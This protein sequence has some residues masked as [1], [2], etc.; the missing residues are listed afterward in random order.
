MR[1]CLASTKQGIIMQEEV[2]NTIEP[3]QEL[4]PEPEMATSTEAPPSQ[5]SDKDRNMANMR[6]T[7][8]N[9]TAQIEQMKD[10]NTHEEEAVSYG[11]FKKVKKELA[12]VRDA[13]LLHSDHNDYHQIV[14]PKNE[15]E[16]QKHNPQLFDALYSVPSAYKNGLGVYHAIK[17]MKEAKKNQG[18]AKEKLE[19][20]KKVPNLSPENQM[21]SRIETRENRTF[22]ERKAHLQEFRKRMMAGQV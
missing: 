4:P 15:A 10:A 14:N 5:E 11:E 8:R 13:L 20:N 6:A 19:Q 7:I 17:L 3:T 21:S 9:L 18:Q 22:Q 1:T 2:E 12:L 16:L